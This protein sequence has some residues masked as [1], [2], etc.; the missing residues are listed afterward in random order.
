M[1][2]PLKHFRQKDR[3]T[4]GWC[5]CR[6]VYHHY[7][8]PSTRVRTGLGTDEQ[9]IPFLS[10]SQGVLPSAMLRQL[11]SDGFLVDVLPV[12]RRS[13][14]AICRHLDK[15]HPAIGLQGD[16]VETLHWVVI[17]GHSG[18]YLHIMDSLSHTSSG[19]R[20][21]MKKDAV[22]NFISFFSI[23][24]ND[25]ESRKTSLLEILKSFPELRH[26]TKIIRNHFRE[27]NGEVVP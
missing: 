10:G 22:K 27:R 4:C 17:G 25:G 5:A 15:G 16:Y 1:R 2:L 18:E 24:G 14:N 9:A 19:W 23:S 11:R 20:K 12:T 3:H 7:G 21:T 6:V 13:V 26:V 8:I